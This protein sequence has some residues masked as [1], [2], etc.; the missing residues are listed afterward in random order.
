MLSQ[1]SDEDL[2]A[3]SATNYGLGGGGRADLPLR[4]RD[5]ATGRGK[6][7]ALPFGDPVFVEISFI[8]YFCIHCEQGDICPQGRSRQR[9]V[10][11]L[12]GA[13]R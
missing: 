9:G 1:A 13:G 5:L 3:R 11:A 12:L 2:L 7:H 4:R 6:E 10:N 8:R